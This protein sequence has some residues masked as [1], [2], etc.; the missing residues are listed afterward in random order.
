VFALTDFQCYVHPLEGSRI[1]VWYAEVVE[2]G[3]LATS[4]IH[5]CLLDVARLQPIGDLR[6][7]A[8]LLGKSR[9]FYAEG[10]MIAEFAIPTDLDD[11]VHEV[12]IPSEFSSCGELLVLAHSTA[13]GRVENHFDTMHLRLWVLDCRSGKLE[14]VPQDWYNEG[15]YDFGY[16]WVTRVARLHDGVGVVGEGIRL[17]IFR[18]DDSLRKVDAWLIEDLFY[19]PRAPGAAT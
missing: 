10:G 6:A 7:A 19:A 16:Q 14:I 17:G 5:F 15:S 8:S 1:L 4:A 9:R 12:L 18:L 2:Q 13:Q 3:V 11:G